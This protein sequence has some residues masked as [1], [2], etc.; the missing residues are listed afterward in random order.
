MYNPLRAQLDPENVP[1]AWVNA[2]SL[3]GNQGQGVKVGVLDS[4]AQADNPALINRISWFKDYVDSSNTTPKET[5]G[6]GTMMAEIIG[7]TANANGSG[8]NPF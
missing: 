5:D 1:L 7:G 8:G 3:T 4:G 2:Q 6:H